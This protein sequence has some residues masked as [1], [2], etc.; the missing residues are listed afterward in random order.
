M[1]YTYTYL[2]R[3][4]KQRKRQPSPNLVIAKNKAENVFY[5]LANE[6]EERKEYMNVDFENQKQNVT[7][8]PTFTT[9][10]S[11]LNNGYLTIRFN[12]IEPFSVEFNSVLISNKSYEEIFCLILFLCLFCILQ[13]Y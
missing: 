9:G 5:N 10:K 1:N 4:R 11:K 7:D 13:M 6:V 12:K 2:Y 3:K 8:N